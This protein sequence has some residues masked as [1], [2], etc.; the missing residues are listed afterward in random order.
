MRP[1]CDQESTSCAA[2]CGPTPGWS[3]SCGASLRVSVSISRASS[4]SSAVSCRTRRAIEREREQ[5]AAQLGIASA[6]G[7]RRREALQQPCTC[8]RPQLAAQRLR[9]RDQQ[10][11][12]LA[13]PGSLGVDG[14]FACGHQR[15]Q[16]LAFTAGPRRRR[17]LWREHAAGGTDRVERVGLAA[18]AAL[19]PQPADLEHPLATAGEEARETGTERACPL[20]RERTPPRRVLLAEQE[21]LRVAVAVCGDVRLEH[22]RAAVERRRPR[23]H[24]SR[25]ADRHQRRSPA[26]LQASVTD[27]QPR[28]GGHIRCRSGDEDRGRQ[29]CDGSR[30]NRADRLLIRP[31]SGRQAGT[32]L[33]ARTHHWK[34][35]RSGVI[36]KSSHEQRAPAPP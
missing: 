15:L 34:D 1:W 33:S 3:S 9:G 2:A 8:E 29:N 27:L 18:R 24:A 26:D 10:V 22:D 23:A 5:A 11:S 28:V 30:P 20:D 25:G 6:V 14:A 35:T 32:G 12:Q 17:P 13:E 7:P 4:R 36:R 31:A 16:R 21:R 19:P